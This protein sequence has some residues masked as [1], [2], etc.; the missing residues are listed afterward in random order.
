[1]K[2]STYAFFGREWGKRTKRIADLIPPHASVVDLGGGEENLREYLREPGQ[3]V[4]IDRYPCRPSTLVA[5]FNAGE[6][7]LVA[8]DYIVAQGLVEY[9]D[10]PQEF[11][12]RIRQYGPMLIFTWLDPGVRTAESRNHFKL[13]YILRCLRRAGWRVMLSGAIPKHQFIFYC[14][15]V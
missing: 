6:Y 15:R 1:M 10:R 3:Y 13:P 2:N 9:L 5:D 14:T 12:T 11:F 8:A 4:S 7:P